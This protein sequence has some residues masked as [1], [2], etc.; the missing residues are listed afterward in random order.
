MKGEV[1]EHP[2]FIIQLLAVANKAA[3][4]YI[5]FTTAVEHI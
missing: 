2:D 3:N 4:L 5:K 1:V